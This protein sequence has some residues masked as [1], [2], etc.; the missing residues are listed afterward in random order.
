[1]SIRVVVVNRRFEGVGGERFHFYDPPGDEGRVGFGE[2][3]A[4]GSSAS[5]PFS[6]IFPTATADIDVRSGRDAWQTL[7]GP[8]KK[9]DSVLEQE[10]EAGD[11]V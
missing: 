10:T 2:E 3:E 8:P 11:S 7:F 5:G 4:D 1:M 6:G 9:R